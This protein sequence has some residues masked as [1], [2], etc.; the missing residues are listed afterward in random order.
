MGCDA[1]DDILKLKLGIEFLS[2]KPPD[3]SLKEKS[4]ILILSGIE[5]GPLR[6]RQRLFFCATEADWC[7]YYVCEAFW[8]LLDETLST[9]VSYFMD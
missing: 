2:I 9:N 8:S 5:L 6:A 1:S 4:E 7:Q 3:L